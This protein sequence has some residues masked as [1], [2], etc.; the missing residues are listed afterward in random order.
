MGDGFWVRAC[1]KG[2][3]CAKHRAQQGSDARSQAGGRGVGKMRKGFIRQ[4]EESALRLVRS[5]DSAK[6]Y[7]QSQV[8]HSHFFS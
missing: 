8:T 1:V 5:R 6:I 3:R 4:A 7:E 2:T